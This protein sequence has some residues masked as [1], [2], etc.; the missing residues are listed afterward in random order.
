VPPAPGGDPARNPEVLPSGRNIHALNPWSVPSPAAVK[1]GRML[2]ERLLERMGRI[3]E[4]VA[5]VLWGTDNIKT[6]GEGVAQALWLLGAVPEPDSLGRMSRVRLVDLAELGRPRIDVV[7]TCSGIFRDLFPSVMQLLDQ[8]VIAA[9]TADEPLEQ[10]FVRKRALAMAEQLRV[11]LATAARRVFAARPGQYGTGVNHVVQEGAWEQAGDLGKVYL[12]R[13]GF[14]YGRGD[15]AAREGEVL[16]AALATTD[17]AVQHMDSVELGLADIDHYFE[18][19]GG[20]SAAVESLRGA[21]PETYVFDTAAAGG[22]ARPLA[23][24]LRLESRTRLLNPRWVEGMLQHGYQGVHE[25]AQRLDHTYG[26]QATARAVDGWVFTGAAHM[27][28]EQADRLKAL[29]PQA[30]LRMAGRLL[31]AHERGLWQGSEQD[32]SSLRE[33]RD[34]VEAMMEG[35]A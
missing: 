8:A 20:I 27:L 5:M 19:L 33:M 18:H 17:T 7:A 25:I 23:E 10:N 13:M 16:R 35:I 12:E 21:R 22:K 4:S 26:W 14:T 30:L 29:N 28:Q 11:P 31:E 32:V 1:T 2:A 24:A 6:Q 3:P 34:G 9:A 15:E